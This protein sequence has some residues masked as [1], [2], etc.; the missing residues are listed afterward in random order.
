VLHYAVYVLAVV[1]QIKLNGFAA[2]INYDL[3]NLFLN[4]SSDMIYSLIYLYFPLSPSID[5]L[6]SLS[7]PGWA[8]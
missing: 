2:S 6:K 4:W 8:L 1:F 5:N 7:M 3:H